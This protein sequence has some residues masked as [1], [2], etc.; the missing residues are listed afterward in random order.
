MTTPFTEFD[1]KV[2][3]A[4][5]AG[6]DHFTKIMAHGD[7]KQHAQRIAQQPGISRGGR[8]FGVHILERRLQA[9]RRAG[10]IAYVERAWKAVGAQQ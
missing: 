4:V 9:L 10:K 3:D 1:Q 5:S 8:L 7:I 6:S 2:L